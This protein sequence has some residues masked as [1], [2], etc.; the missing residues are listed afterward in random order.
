MKILFFKILAVI[1]GLLFIVFHVNA[2]KF[3]FH[4]E[5]LNDSSNRLEGK[6][7]GTVFVLTSKINSNYFFHR[8]WYDGTITL[9]D[10]DVFDG[11][12]LR[13]QAFDNEL[14]VYNNNLRNLFVVDK[15]KVNHFTVITPG[16][17]QKFV[18]LFYDGYPKGERYYEVLYDGRRKLLAYHQVIEEK[19]RPFVDQFGIMK[20]TNYRLITIYYMHT[21]KAGFQRIRLQRRSL[22]SHFPDNKRELRRLLRRNNLDV[23]EEPGM[24]RAFKLLD[25]SGYFN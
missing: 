15:E 14:V 4:W 2:Q 5:Q 16:E 8:D 13:F 9:E 24:I 25:E 18:K 17:T 12:K 7:T 6:L 10:N 21:S 1:S 11:M 20:D 23:F 19:T 22:L 3:E